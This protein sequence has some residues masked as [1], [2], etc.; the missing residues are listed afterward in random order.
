MKKWRT[1]LTS[2]CLM[3]SLTACSSAPVVVTETREVPVLPPV[4]WLQDCDTPG[5][6]GDR[7]RDLWAAYQARGASLEACNAEKAQLRQWREKNRDK[8]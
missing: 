4:E 7:N 2:A 5:L 1:G 3:L 6:A 8:D